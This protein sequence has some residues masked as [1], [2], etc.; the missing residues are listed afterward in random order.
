MLAAEPITGTTATD[1]ANTVISALRD[2]A[3]FGL[4]FMS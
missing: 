3:W 1:A 4:F 2:H